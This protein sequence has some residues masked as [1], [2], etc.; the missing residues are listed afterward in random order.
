M[1]EITRFLD[2]DPVSLHFAE[3]PFVGCLS[4]LPRDTLRLINSLVPIVFI[5]CGL[6]QAR[7]YRDVLVAQRHVRSF[8]APLVSCRHVCIF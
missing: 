2:L 1:S 4:T 7:R 3:I 6:D 5:V 8:G